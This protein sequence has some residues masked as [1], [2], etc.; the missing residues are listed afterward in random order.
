VWSP[1]PYRARGQAVH[2]DGE[3]PRTA[4]HRDVAVAV[5]AEQRDA[6]A[7][8]L[9][10]Q[11]RG[12]VAVVVVPSHADDRDRRVR[13]GHVVGVEVRRPVVRHLQHVGP[14][15][16]TRIDDRAL[17]LD[18]GVAGQQQPHAL[19]LG[20]QHERRVVGVGAGAV[21]GAHRSEDFQ[22]HPADLQL[23]PDRR[24]LHRQTRLRRDGVHDRRA[25]LRVVQR[26]REQSAD[27]A[28]AHHPGQPADVIDV[29]MGQDEQGDPIDAEVA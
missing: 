17:R 28:P 13:G 7:G 12:R 6:E 26:P 29:E 25:D 14:Q 16:G 4:G 11:D 2:H 23:R 10:E 24:G 8:H 22:R 21:E 9:V 3:V 5:G 18:L 20:P 27:C 1:Q 15:V 19:D